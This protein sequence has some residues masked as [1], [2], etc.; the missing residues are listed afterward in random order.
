MLRAARCAAVKQV[1]TLMCDPDFSRYR[2][3]RPSVVPVVPATPGWAESAG[4]AAGWAPK[5]AAATASPTTAREQR[6][7]FARDI[8][9]STDEFDSRRGY[10]TD[11][12]RTIND[13]SS[14][15]Q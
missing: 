9:H 3:T 11:R 12:R 13:R 2:Q 5:A 10:S 1:R 6:S 4:V 15:R 7:T 8:R 14:T